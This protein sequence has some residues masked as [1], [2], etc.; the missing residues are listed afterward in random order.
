MR[1]RE[2]ERALNWAIQNQTRDEL[3]GYYFRICVT[4]GTLIAQPQPNFKIVVG[5]HL[6]AESKLYEA[7]DLLAYQIIQK[8]KGQRI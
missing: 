1:T 3:A 4:I 5:A 2:L 8:I 7:R 6:V